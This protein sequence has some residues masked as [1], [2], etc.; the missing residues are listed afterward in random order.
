MVSMTARAVYWHEGMFLRPHQLQAAE[1]HQ[2]YVLQTGEKWDHHY[3]WGLRTVEIDREAL[4]NHR[5]VIRQ[6]QARLRDGSLVAVPEDGMLPAR[7][8]KAAFQRDSNLTVFLAI[9]V[10]RLGR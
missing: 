9:P 10:I 1:R 7:D 5:L 4:S 6:L 8:L 3:N 2:A